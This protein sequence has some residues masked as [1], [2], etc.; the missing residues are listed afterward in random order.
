MKRRAQGEWL[1]IDR[2]TVLTAGMAVAAASALRSRA[3]FAQRRRFFLTE[4]EVAFLTAACDTLIPRDDYPSASEAGVVDYIDLQ[5]ATGYGAGAGLYLQGPFEEGA[6]EQGWQVGMT[7]AELMRAGVA[8]ADDAAGGASG[9]FEGL[10]QSDREA[11]LT[12]LEND[13]RD[14]GDVPAKRFFTE[15]WSLTNE[16]YFADPAYNGNRGYAGWLMIGFP[17]AHAYYLSNVD[18]W[19]TAW[20][21]RPR[22]IAHRPGVGSRPFLP[23]ELPSRERG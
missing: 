9:G 1:T 7:P 18:D 6:P 16:G 13:T 10:S 22:G 11:F 3:A 12:E 21:A 23:S 5:M 17:G 4:A 15:L 14:L 2:R 8:A 20:A 19:N